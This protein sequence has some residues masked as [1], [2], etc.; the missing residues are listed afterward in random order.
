MQ[1]FFG[2]DSC[3]AVTQMIAVVKQIGVDRDF[4]IAGEVIVLHLISFLQVEY[5]PSQV[6][7]DVRSLF[8][9]KRVVLLIICRRKKNNPDA[10]CLEPFDRS[11]EGVRC[12]LHKT[13]MGVCHLS[14]TRYIS[15]GNFLG[16][17]L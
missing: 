3:S 4:R 1:Q 16:M 9:E 2:K 11:G 5:A 17:S 10:S 6:R 14:G 7:N 8:F 12:I 13:W 15:P